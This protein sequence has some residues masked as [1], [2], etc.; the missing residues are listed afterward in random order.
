MTTRMTITMALVYWVPMAPAFSAS[1]RTHD[2]FLDFYLSPA[3]GLL[4]FYLKLLI[5]DW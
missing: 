5:L 1:E 2:G 3:D 4:G